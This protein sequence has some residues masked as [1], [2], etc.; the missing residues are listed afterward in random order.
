MQR[1]QQGMTLIS[2]ILI[3]A[4]AAFFGFLAMRLFPVYSEYYSAVNDI[5]AVTQAA[6]AQ[7]QGLPQIKDSLYRRF[8]ISYVDNIN[9][10]KNVKLVNGP[11]GKTLE[12]NY[13]V[14]KPLMYNLDFV[15]K[16]ERSFPVSGQ[17]GVE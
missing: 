10:D 7:N 13:E 3:L 2:F 12:L 1:T 16:F 4:L 15:A 6:G 14:R 8:Q 9:L 5:K 17:P 11:A